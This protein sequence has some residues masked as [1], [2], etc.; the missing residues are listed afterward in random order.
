MV[1][2]QHSQFV[3]VTVKVIITVTRANYTP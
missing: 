2:I 1:H 3:E